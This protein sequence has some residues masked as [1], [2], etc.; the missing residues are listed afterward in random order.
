MTVSE[1]IRDLQ[2]MPQHLPVLIL[3][4]SC[5]INDECGEVEIYFDEENAIPANDVRFS[6][7]FVLIKGGD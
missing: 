7:S 5:C 4:V 6:G 1:L 3:P 2:A